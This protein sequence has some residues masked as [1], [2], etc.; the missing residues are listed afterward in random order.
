MVWLKISLSNHS[1]SV[2]CFIIDKV[3]HYHTPYNLQ[4]LH[5]PQ[6]SYSQHFTDIPLCSLGQDNQIKLWTI[7]CEFSLVESTKSPIWSHT[8]DLSEQYWQN[9]S[10]IHYLLLTW[11][12]PR[13]ILWRWQDNMNVQK[14]QKIIRAKLIWLNSPRILSNSRQWQTVVDIDRVER[15]IKS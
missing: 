8:M 11:S 4:N 13:K 1:S 5:L 12:L 14:K 10:T 6:P 7:L 9:P 2:P 3:Q 15:Q